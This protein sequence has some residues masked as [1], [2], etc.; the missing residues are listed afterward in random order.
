MSK[1]LN[2]DECW[3]KPCNKLCNRTYCDRVGRCICAKTECVCFEK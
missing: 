1:K 2:I 3:F